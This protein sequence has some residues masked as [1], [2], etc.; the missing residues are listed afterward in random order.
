MVNP[1][2]LI[3]HPSDAVTHTFALAPCNGIERE[4]EDEDEV[5]EETRF[6]ETSACTEA[7]AGASSRAFA[8]HRHEAN[9][10]M[11]G[12]LGAFAHLPRVSPPGDFA[13]APWRDM[14]KAAVLEAEKTC[15][16]FRL[17]AR[18]LDGL[19]FENPEAR[20]AL[21]ASLER[22]YRIDAADAHR[23]WDDRIATLVRLLEVW[24]SFDQS[25]AYKSKNLDRFQSC[26]QRLSLNYDRMMDSLRRASQ[27]ITKAT[28]S[29]FTHGEPQ[30]EP[31][32]I[33]QGAIADQVVL[34]ACAH[35]F[36]EDCIKQ[37][38]HNHKQCPL[39]RADI[40]ECLENQGD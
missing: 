27:R 9:E 22:K 16:G 29:R 15:A 37:W 39:C 40:K 2:D 31:C 10:A 3:F 4:D 7:L 17:R 1:V 23:E 6:L 28:L 25:T 21:L 13:A 35:C 14:F 11:R 26:S 12:L 30:D 18:L 24:G 36:H 8:R 33:C 38:L 20:R 19:T 32:S 5:V 34:L